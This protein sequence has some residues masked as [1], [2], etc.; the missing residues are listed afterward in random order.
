MGTR[1]PSVSL[2][3]NVLDIHLRFLFN[4]LDRWHDRFGDCLPR[5][6]EGY[7]VEVKPFLVRHMVGF[8]VNEVV[9]KLYKTMSALDVHTW[10]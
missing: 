3:F 9:R 2:L 10:D 7:V 8:V 1:P 5:H 6:R 4:L